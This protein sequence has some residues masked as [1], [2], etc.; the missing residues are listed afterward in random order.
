MVTRIDA[1]DPAFGPPTVRLSNGRVVSNPLA[2]VIRFAYPTRGEGQLRAPSL[3][4]LNVRVTRRFQL[5]RVRFDASVDVFNLTNNGADQGFLFTANQTYSPLFGQ[6]TDRQ[7][8]RSA[9]V[10]F[11]ASF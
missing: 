11:R 8:P 2:T 1:P 10:V 3:H 5:E 7:G 9:Q 4:G 6:T